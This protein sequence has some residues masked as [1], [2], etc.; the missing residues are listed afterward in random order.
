MFDLQKKSNF[1]KMRLRNIDREVE[2]VFS[3]LLV[4]ACTF[5]A[6]ILIGAGSIVGGLLFLVPL[7]VAGHAYWDD[8]RAGP[9][10]A[11]DEDKA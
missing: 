5:M 4:I 10:P 8:W 3:T 6:V 7:V 9:D 1:Y 11:A 2:P